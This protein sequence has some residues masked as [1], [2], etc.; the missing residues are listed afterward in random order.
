M[1]RAMCK[2]PRHSFHKQLHRSSTGLL[3]A[4]LLLPGSVVQAQALTSTTSPVPSVPAVTLAEALDYARTHQPELRA[5]RERFLAVAADARIP[6]AQWLPSIGATAQVVASSANNSTA[7]VLASRDVDLPRIGSTTITS[8]PRWQPYATT[9]GALG[10]RQEVFDFGRIAAQT[11]AGNALVAIERDRLQLTRLDITLIVT[12]AYY[13]VRA[14]HAVLQAASQAEARAKVHSE[15]ADVAVKSGLRP[16]IERTRAAADLTRFAAG[17]I[18]AEGNVRVAR[19]VLAAAVGFPEPELDSAG[20][21]EALPGIPSLAQVEQRALAFQ[22]EILE[23]I[24]RQK[25][26]HAQTTAIAAAERPNLFASASISARAG[27]ASATNGQVPEGQGFIPTVPNYDVGLVLSWPLYEPTIDAAV[28]AS[29]QR[30]WT[31]NAE[32][33]SAQQKARTLAQQVYRRTRIAESALEALAQAAAAARANYDQADARFRAGM[34]T[35]TELADAEAI[36]LDAEVQQ[37]VGGF[38][39][40]TARAQLARVMGD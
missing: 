17:R 4:A 26:Q 24:D 13:A 38:E 28:G 25:A 22:P 14:A 10:L 19:S 2:C 21:A 40:A 27:G 7:T 8:S 15:F 32:L 12:Q 39:L 18:R 3:L 1:G 33:A 30:E 9:L 31:Y 36:R 29:K 16:P 5:A 35:S 23:A 6:S 34:G 11:A 37:A 20:A